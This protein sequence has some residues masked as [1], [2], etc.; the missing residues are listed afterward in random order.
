MTQF[1]CTFPFKTVDANTSNV[2]PFETNGNFYDFQ[3]LR[4]KLKII[5]YDRHEYENMT[6][7]YSKSSFEG[8]R[9]K[10]ILS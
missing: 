8:L 6:H 5:L 10:P 3:W 1:E 7:S 4:K 2:K 9:A